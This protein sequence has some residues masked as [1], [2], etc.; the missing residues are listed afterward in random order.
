[1]PRTLE[2]KLKALKP[3]R[4]AAVEAEADQLHAAYRLRIQS[5]DT[6]R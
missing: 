6:K 2:A 4:R 1:M 5:I 3:E